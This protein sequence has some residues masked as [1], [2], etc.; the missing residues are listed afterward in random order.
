[1]YLERQMLI[2][3]N[4]S[5]RLLKKKRTPLLLLPLELLALVLTLGIYIILSLLVQVKVKLE[6]FNQLDED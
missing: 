4:Q 2:Q 1:M 5:V 3:E 6:S